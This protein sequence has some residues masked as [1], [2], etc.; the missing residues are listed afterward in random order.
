MKNK[1]HAYSSFRQMK[2]SLIDKEFHAT[3]RQN[4]ISHP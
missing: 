2:A 4:K 1:K 3:L